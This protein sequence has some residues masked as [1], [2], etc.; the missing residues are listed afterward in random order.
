MMST[1]VYQILG[2]DSSA[3]SKE[4]KRA[5]A[6]LIK[7]F[8]PDTHPV[9]FGNIRQA[10]EIASAQYL[11]DLASQPQTRDDQ[12]EPAQPAGHAAVEYAPAEQGQLADPEPVPAP[13]VAR[14]ELPVMEFLVQ[15]SQLAERHEEQSAQQLTL[16]FLGRLNAYSLDECSQIELEILNWIFTFRHPLLLTFIELDRYYRWTETQGFSLRE[17]SPGEVAWLQDFRQLAYDYQ[18]ALSQKNINLSTVHS[19]LPG[20]LLSKA[21]IAQRKQWQ[22]R[23]DELNLAALKTYFKPPPASSYAITRE[24]IFFSL[25][26]AGIALLL[27]SATKLDI[28]S[29]LVA[30]L[31]FLVTLAARAVVIPVLRLLVKYNQVT[32]RLRY[33][34]YIFVA[35]MFFHGAD[36][37]LKETADRHS[38]QRQ[39]LNSMQQPALHDESPVICN[40]QE[41]REAPVYPDESRRLGEEGK[42]KVK[43]HV[44]MSGA[45]ISA[46]IME[47][48]G[49]ERLDNESLRAVRR[50]C[51]VPPKREFY[52]VAPFS[53]RMDSPA[54]HMGF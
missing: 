25:F 45:V 14:A 46:E 23:C 49:F 31:A 43:F 12:A 19:R 7:Q 33:F 34:I 30:A 50:W 39:A 8:R 2:I 22:R 6:R 41:K 36:Y 21:D 13:P 1:D 47:S 3:D 28:V 4:I 26:P 53:F 32:Y 17:F 9:E 27:A 18:Q 42:V 29:F 40:Q 44:D 16:A 5:Y 10:Y 51:F 52:M 37:V 48:S 11:H 15:L 54:D 20:F 38:M 35:M 24:D